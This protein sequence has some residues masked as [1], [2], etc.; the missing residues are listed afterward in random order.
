MCECTVSTAAPAAVLSA[1]STSVLLFLMLIM[2]MRALHVLRAQSVESGNSLAPPFSIISE[3]ELARKL[4]L[5][6]VSFGDSADED[7]NFFCEYRFRNPADE[8]FGPVRIRF[9]RFSRRRGGPM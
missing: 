6:E 2:M 5:C 4:T 9:Q 7:V 1:V 8:E 3:N